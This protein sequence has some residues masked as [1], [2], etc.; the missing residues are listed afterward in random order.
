MYFDAIQVNNRDLSIA[1]LRT[2]INKRKEEH[3]AFLSRK[4]KGGLRT[5]EGKSDAFVSKE[6]G[7]AEVDRETS[8]GVH[9]GDAPEAAEPMDV[10]LGNV[11]EPSNGVGVKAQ[12]E[13]KPPRVLE[14]LDLDFVFSVK[15]LN[16]LFFYRKIIL[17][18]TTSR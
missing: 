6:N 14:V 10:S 18:N 3:E 8:N 17:N 12:R 11:G 1:V 5:F 9:D 16:R 4:A 13:L 2:F 15:I 7:S